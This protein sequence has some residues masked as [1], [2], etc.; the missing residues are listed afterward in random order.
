MWL[1]LI[2]PQYGLRIMQKRADLSFMFE[3]TQEQPGGLHL[4]SMNQGCYRSAGAGAGASDS[5]SDT[6]EYYGGGR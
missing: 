5:G 2:S 4:S 1:I 6:E 3:E